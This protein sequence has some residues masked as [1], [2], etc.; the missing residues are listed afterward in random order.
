V[1]APAPP[2]AAVAIINRLLPQST[3]LVVLIVRIL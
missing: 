3:L 2:T 1:T